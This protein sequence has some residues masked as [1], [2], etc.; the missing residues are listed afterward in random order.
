M[1]ISPSVQLA[2]PRT[3]P[4]AP[5]T[6]A[7]SGLKDVAREFEKM[8]VAEMLRLTELGGTI[9]GPF[10]GGFGEE[11]FQ[12]FLIDAYA[13]QIAETG[14]FGIADTIFQALSRSDGR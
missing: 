6:D 7:D 12:T 13:E 5:A 2:V 4:D 11:A 8:F 9:D 10:T 1:D 3:R 14:Q